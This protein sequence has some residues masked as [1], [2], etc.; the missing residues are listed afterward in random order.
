MSFEN[1]GAFSIICPHLKGSRD[2][3]SCDVLKDYLRNIA[4]VNI[5]F[6]LSRHYEICHVYRSDLKRESISAIELSY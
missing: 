5:K 6:C 2:G 3:A 4:D 1:T